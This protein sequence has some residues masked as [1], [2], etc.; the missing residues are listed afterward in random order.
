[1]KDIYKALCFIILGL[2]CVGTGC[3]ATNVITC[4]FMA[5]SNALVTAG[6]GDIILV[7]AGSC[8]WDSPISLVAG[9]SF[10][11]RGSGSNSTTLISLATNN[12]CPLWVRNISSALFTISDFNL[13]GGTNNGWGF[14]NVGENTPTKFKGKFRIHSIQ[15]TN[16]IY[17]GFTVGYGDAFGVIDH[18]YLTF[19]PG[20]PGSAQ[21]ISFGGN[22]ALSWTTPNPLGTMNAVYVE[23]CFIQSRTNKGNGF[24]DSYE[25]AQFV[26]RHC[27]LDGAA[28]AGTH[29]YD[30]SE[31]SARSFEIYDNVVTNGKPMTPFLEFRGGTGVVFSNVI[32]GWGT[33]AQLASYR[34]CLADHSSTGHGQLDGTSTNLLDGNIDGT[35]YPGHQQVGVIISS[36]TTREQVTLPIY[37]WA[38]TFSGIDATFTVQGP[39]SCGPIT[40]II[41]EG[42][43]FYNNTI[44]PGY[45]PLLYPH[46]LTQSTFSG[47]PQPPT[48]L[49]VLR[50]F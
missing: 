50:T 10:T 48:G 11:F 3:G 39:Y 9:R 28:T 23:D 16:I 17:R 34:S 33:F 30:S 6:E 32:S 13:V 36:P 46:P 40:N 41:K 31:N 18:C 19:A 37:G 1:M 38:N 29:G 47:F 21:P 8:V 35:G 15:M 25:G 2:S 4:N 20:A 43:D 27:T 7:R 12:A 49:R 45:T 44:A 42:R 26:V 5:I 22:S 24:W 14:I